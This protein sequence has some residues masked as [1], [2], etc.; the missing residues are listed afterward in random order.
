[1][2]SLPPEILRYITN[3]LPP[4]TL[5]TIRLCWRFLDAFILPGLFH[6]AKVKFTEEHLKKLQ[7]IA[8]SRHL[9]PHVQ[10]LIWITEGTR[11][12]HDDPHGHVNTWAGHEDYIKDFRH[13]FFL[14]A[15]FPATHLRNISR[16]YVLHDAGV[17]PA[18]IGAT[19]EAWFCVKRKQDPSALAWKEPLEK[20][21]RL[22]L[23]VDVAGPYG[24]VKEVTNPVFKFLLA[25]AVNLRELSLRSRR[26]GS[27]F[28]PEV[29]STWVLMELLRVCRWKF[30][31]TI[32]ITCGRFPEALDLYFTK[33]MRS[34]AKTLKHILFH[35]CCPEKQVVGI[36]RGAASIKDLKLHRFL[37]FPHREGQPEAKEPRIV[38][39]RLVLDFINSKDPSLDPFKEW[40]PARGSSWG[41][42]AE[43]PAS[44][45]EEWPKDDGMPFTCGQC[46]EKY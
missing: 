26:T 1:M 20:L 19:E 10:E 31:R 15:S 28:I 30:L 9:A 44:I 35:H 14:P 37:I 21:L 12:T 36:I 4:S 7:G 11:D 8:L 46:A 17:S 32:K 42:V 38:P 27:H 2:E 6:T 23:R 13:H 39:E 5:K 16:F 45:L 24:G 3:D 43:T 41:T 34:H 25:E 33:F 18:T 40:E 22:D 29:I